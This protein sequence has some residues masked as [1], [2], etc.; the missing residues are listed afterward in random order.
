MLLGGDADAFGGDGKIGGDGNAKKDG[1][2]G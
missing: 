2:G 1:E